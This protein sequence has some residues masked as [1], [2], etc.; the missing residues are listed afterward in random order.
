MEL[1]MRTYG[2]L[3]AREPRRYGLRGDDVLYWVKK[4]LEGG[5]VAPLSLLDER[6]LP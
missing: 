6:A 1:S 4:A 2:D 3:L 5:V